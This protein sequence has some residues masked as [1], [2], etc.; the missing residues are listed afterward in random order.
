MGKKN[1]WY[2]TIGKVEF[3]K[4]SYAKITSPALVPKS[5]AVKN[6]GMVHGKVDVPSSL[7]ANVSTSASMSFEDDIVPS[8]KFPF[9]SRTLGENDTNSAG[10][11]NKSPAVM[12]VDKPEKVPDLRLYDS[13]LGSENRGLFVLISKRVTF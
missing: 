6:I 3:V 9:L 11:S 10:S 4:D 5:A 13:D 1:K 8:P 7:L 12:G 2:S